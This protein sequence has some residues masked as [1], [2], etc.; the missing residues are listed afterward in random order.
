M[1]TVIRW[2]PLAASVAP[3]VARAQAAT[4]PATPSLAGEILAVVVPL[5]L[6]IAA[7]LLVLRLARRRYGLSGGD[8]PLSVVQVLAV[9]P[10]E[11]VVVLRTRAGN[12]LAVGVS[13]Q[14]VNLIAR[15]EPGDVAPPAGSASSLNESDTD[16]GVRPSG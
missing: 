3:V 8:A 2:L 5:A 10:R 6:I 9:G 1:S 11:R 14:S 12:A 4:S 13:A 16:I 7:L 15:L